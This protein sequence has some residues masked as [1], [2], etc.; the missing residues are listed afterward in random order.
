[1]E[2]QLMVEII[3]YSLMFATTHIRNAVSK[4]HTLI[5]DQEMTLM[6]VTD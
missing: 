4:I 1:M 5:Y 2:S 6:F 3:I